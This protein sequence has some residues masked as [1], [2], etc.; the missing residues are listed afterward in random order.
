MKTVY[1]DSFYT[2]INSGSKRSAEKVIPIIKDI[3]KPKSVLDVGCGEGV[4]L[5]TWQE[6][7][8]NNTL[9]IDNHHINKNNFLLNEECFIASNLEKEFD[10]KKKFDLVMSLEVAEHLPH[11]TS[12]NFIRSLIRHGDLVLFSAAQPGQG[13]HNHINEQSLEFWRDLFLKNNYIAVDVLRP[14]L[15]QLKEVEAW[16]KY[17]TILY[18]SQDSPIL[19]NDSIKPYIVPTNEKLET[20]TSKLWWLR[21]SIVSLLP[22][23]L[24][25]LLS[26]INIAI[27]SK[28][29]K[30]LSRQK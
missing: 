27:Q 20:R 21:L 23:P 8:I 5:L 2:Y 28:L 29:H 24:I 13:G 11:N 15:R 12:T 9:G 17:N 1:D 19:E 6:N 10:L 26:Q 4:W 18:I 14:K 30:S 7:N 25:K 22:S 16:Y 3:L